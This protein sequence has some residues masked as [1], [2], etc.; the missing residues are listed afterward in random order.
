MRCAGFLEERDSLLEQ[1]HKAERRSRK[2]GTC[3]KGA[4]VATVLSLPQ[5]LTRMGQETSY[6]KDTRV[7]E[8]HVHENR[9]CVVRGGAVGNVPEWVTR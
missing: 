9:A 2:S 3:G 6:R 7:L 8:S 1:E 5:K 4:R